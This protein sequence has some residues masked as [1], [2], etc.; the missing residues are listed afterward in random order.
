MEQMRQFY[1][2]IKSKL[3]GESRVGINLKVPNDDA[4]EDTDF[5]KRT[6]T[7][8][9]LETHDD[10]TADFM[11]MRVEFF[12]D[13]RITEKSHIRVALE[14]LKDLAMNRISIVAPS[15]LL[16]YLRDE[17]QGEIQMIDREVKEFCELEW[18]N[19][20]SEMRREE[21]EEQELLISKWQ[22]EYLKI[23]NQI[24]SASS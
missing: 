15:T 16:Y 23:E 24:K 18:S 22:L 8:N 13:V 17:L 10:D 20:K 11:D 12:S 21:L 14:I 19:S 4:D 9:R 7:R 6:N 3:S 1:K 5:R 2:R